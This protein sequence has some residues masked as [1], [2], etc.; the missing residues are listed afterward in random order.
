[1]C[2][3]YIINILIFLL[4]DKIFLCFPKI[5]L[6]HF[7]TS[8]HVIIFLSLAIRK[9]DP[10]NGTTNN[11]LRAD[12]DL[13]QVCLFAPLKSEGIK[14]WKRRARCI[15]AGKFSGETSLSCAPLCNTL[16]SLFYQIPN[17]IGL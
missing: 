6:M 14:N 1:M 13:D 8:E 5:F 7:Y 4:W 17:S 15:Y 9:G 10:Q 11:S 3:K 16:D 12:I 2:R